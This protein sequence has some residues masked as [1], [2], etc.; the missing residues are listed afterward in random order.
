MEW[1]MHILKA[2][3]EAVLKS[4]HT[5]G[6]IEYIGDSHRRC[7]AK[8]WEEF[9]SIDETGR[10]FNM[11]DGVLK[12]FFNDGSDRVVMTMDCVFD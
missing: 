9:V 8:S 5:T 3:M 11:E 10:L 2:I 1:K 12:V 6:D 7:G 4:G